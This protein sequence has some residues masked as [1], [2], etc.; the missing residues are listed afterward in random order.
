[1]RTALFTNFTSEEFIGYWD[2][3]GKKFAPGKSLYMPDYLAEHFAKHLVNRE[4][5][6]RKND[7][8]L[9]IPNGD[10]FVSPK[11]FELSDPKKMQNVP[12]AF[13]DLFNK[14]YTP[15]ELDELGEKRDDIDALIEVANKNIGNDTKV[16][17]VESEDVGKTESTP[18]STEKQ[19]PTKPQVIVPP[20]F[21][22]DE[23]D[24]EE[25]FEGKPVEISTTPAPVTTTPPAPTTTAGPQN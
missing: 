25:S 1:M 2:G 14:A 12:I 7:G 6:R 5:L 20:D 24:S 19:D 15:D 17:N 18:A 8:T 9:I 10:K 4:L 3:K 11:S 22:K 16:E 23:D 13:M 21:D